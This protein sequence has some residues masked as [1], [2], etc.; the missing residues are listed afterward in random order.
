MTPVS[1]LV[2]DALLLLSIVG[3]AWAS[4]AT[5][6]VR[7]SIILFM[8]FGLV[9]AVAWGRLLAPDV[10]LAEAAIGAGLS[11]ALLLA[12]AHRQPRPLPPESTNAPPN[13]GATVVGVVL[14]WVVTLLCAA[15]AGTL[16]WALLHVFGNTPHDM[17]PGA[18]SANLATSGVSNPVTAVLLNFRAYDTLLELAVLLTAVLGI[19]ALGQATPGY[20]PAGPVF[21]GL[22]RWLVPVLILT[23][24]YLL[25]A[26]AHAP[27]GAFQAG[28]ML[29]AAGVVLRLAG[30]ARIGLP[31]G[32]M[33]RIVMSAGVGV[34][35]LIGLT[36]LLLGRPFLGY[37]PAWAGPLILLIETTAMLSIAA[38]LL[39]AFLGGRPEPTG[40]K[41]SA[42]CQCEERSRC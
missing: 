11:G 5:T 29:A 30:R 35:L 41:A 7:R 9:L 18:I 32:F 33:L 40:V 13:Y 2:F 38:T 12:A 22:V 31:D 34:F 3:L 4:L 24:G 19:F 25:W 1:L 10:A 26:G 21:D 14:R 36:L 42:S 39:L 27:G 37:P 28:A 23:A 17:L 15:L 8:A 6:D 16:A 20:R